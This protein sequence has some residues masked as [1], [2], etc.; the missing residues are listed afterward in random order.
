M[1]LAY[2]HPSRVNLSLSQ[3]AKFEGFSKRLFIMGADM[4]SSLWKGG[5][6]AG[7][8]SGPGD[9]GLAQPQLT[10]WELRNS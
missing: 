6:G 7:R 9:V 5:G 10:T 1:W 3:E 8:Q 2:A 4:D